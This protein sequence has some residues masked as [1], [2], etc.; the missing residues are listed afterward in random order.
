MCKKLLK[1]LVVVG[2]AVGMLAT[3]MSAFAA[4]SYTVQ[5]G[6]NLK[7][8]AK[9]LYGDSAKWEAIYE[10]NKDSI[11]NPNLIYEGQVFAIPDSD[12]APAAEAETPAPEPAAEAPAPEPAAEAPAP[13]PA[14]ETP[15]AVPALASL[16]IPT[17]TVKVEK[18]GGWDMSGNKSIWTQTYDTGSR[19]T[20]GHIGWD[21]ALVATAAEST[22]A[23]GVT[24]RSYAFSDPAKN[25]QSA[26]DALASYMTVNPD[27]SFT[28]FVKASGSQ[29]VIVT[30]PALFP[31]G[32]EG[33]K[34][35]PDTNL[36][37][38]DCFIVDGKLHI[39]VTDETFDWLEGTPRP[40]I[41][42]PQY[43]TGAFEALASIIQ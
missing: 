40:D 41:Y 28:A 30:Y 34:N 32:M 10:A 6:D 4:E 43:L 20:G 11:K 31:N 8:I 1:R 25:V 17:A 38:R 15:A 19:M 33:L 9:Q 13:E 39:L 21:G 36:L 35:Y 29:I 27:S 14:A 16:P 18:G 37:A 2:A 5:S 7:K 26:K 22:D 12:A 3:S 42:I 24:Y 23:N